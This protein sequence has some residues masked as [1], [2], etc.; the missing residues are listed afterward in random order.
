LIKEDGRADPPG[1]V[2]IAAISRRE[3]ALPCL[4]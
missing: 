1:L 4:R 2:A 3:L